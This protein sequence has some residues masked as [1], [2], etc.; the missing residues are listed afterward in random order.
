MITELLPIMI[1][2]SE[3]DANRVNDNLNYGRK[4]EILPE[5]T[6]SSRKLKEFHSNFNLCE[7]QSDA[8]IQI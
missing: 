6:C 4:K 1:S 3:S 5:I 7:R 8:E 2:I